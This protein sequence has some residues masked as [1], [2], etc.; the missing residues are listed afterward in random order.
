[1]LSI[2]VDVGT[3]AVKLL[4]L[5]SKGGK[6]TVVDAKSVS[7]PMGAVRGGRIIDVQGVSSA[8]QECIPLFRKYRRAKIVAAISVSQVIVRTMTV[9]LASEKEIKDFLALETERLLPGEGEVVFDFSIL[10]RNTEGT[11]VFVVATYRSAVDPILNILETIGITP[12]I[13]DV[14]VIALLNLYEKQ[15]KGMSLLLDIGA[16]GS[17]LVVFGDKEV[18]LVR[19]TT[20]GGNMFTGV[21]QRVL[22]LDFEAA[23]EVKKSGNI[24]GI[25]KER[26]EEVFSDLYREI[27]RAFD[28]LIGIYRE[29]PVKCVLLSGGGSLTKGL[30]DWLRDRLNV[31]I[32]WTINCREVEGLNGDF[33]KRVIMDVPLG[34]ALRGIEK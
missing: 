3:S 15:C 13:L 25:V 9:P 19:H 26:L 11:D 4:V 21:F 20:I 7:L 10:G 5:Q 17:N 29:I 33:N 31:P 16:G 22:N 14:D 23:E 34:L 1:M 28:Y 2:G 8:L 12:S 32:D 24:D 6:V 27:E 30:L 18:P